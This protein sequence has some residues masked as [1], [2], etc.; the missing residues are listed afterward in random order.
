M[1]QFQNSSYKV[2]AGNRPTNFFI[3][4]I[5]PFSLGQL[6]ALYEHKIFVRELSG[7]FLVLINGV[8]NWENNWRIK[9]YL[10]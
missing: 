7:I 9:F 3:K 10:N 4:K 8:W 5:T 1:K 6:I 2:F